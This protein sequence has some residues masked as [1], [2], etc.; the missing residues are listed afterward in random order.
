MFTVVA[1]TR[2]VVIIGDGFT[3][4]AWLHIIDCD[5]RLEELCTA[6]NEY[7]S[8]AL[9]KP[10]RPVLTANTFELNECFGAGKVTHGSYRCSPEGA[11]SNRT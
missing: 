2:A 8:E 9:T 10:L 4:V 1:G 6:V 11:I 7:L 3:A 5:R